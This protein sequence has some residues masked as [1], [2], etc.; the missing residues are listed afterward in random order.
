M[1]IQLK[2]IDGSWVCSF[3]VGNVLT[4]KVFPAWAACSTWMEKWVKDNASGK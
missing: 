4:E 1:E 2:N 3:R